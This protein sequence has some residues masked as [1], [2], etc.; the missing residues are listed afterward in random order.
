LWS[1]GSPRRKW[2]PKYFR[3][4]CITQNSVLHTCTVWKLRLLRLLLLLL[5]LLL[6]I[7]IIIIIIIITKLPYSGHLCSM[8]L[9]VTKLG[10]TVVMTL[11]GRWTGWHSISPQDTLI[12]LRSSLSAPRV[13]YLMRASPSV[14][15][16]CPCLMIGM[17]N[18]HRNETACDA[19]LR[20]VIQRITNTD[21]SDTQP[22]CQLGMAALGWDVCLRLALPA[23]LK[24]ESLRHFKRGCSNKSSKNTLQKDS[25]AGQW[26]NIN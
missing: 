12:L 17:R 14:S 15:P 21:L 16:H 11:I 1:V 4:C 13:M 9:H 26:G 22:V 3:F 2:N 23:Y 6:P 8:D 18:G 19:S 10:Q 20:S 5:L 7:I 24:R 25:R